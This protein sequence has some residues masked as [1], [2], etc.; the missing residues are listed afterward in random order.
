MHMRW[1]NGRESGLSAVRKCCY[2][3]WRCKKYVIVA[4]GLQL[5]INGDY[6]LFDYGACTYPEGMMGDRLM[7]FQASDINKVVFKGYTDDDERIMVDNIQ[8]AMESLDV[9]RA[10]VRRLKQSMRN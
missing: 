7:Y 10:D 4:R 5:K 1:Q 3:A 9:E 6:K 8:K 2:C